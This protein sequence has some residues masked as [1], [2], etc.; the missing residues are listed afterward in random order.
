MERET[1]RQTETEIERDLH[2][3]LLWVV[4]NKEN[5]GCISVDPFDNSE[6]NHEK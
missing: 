6:K 2:V 1:D 3:W 5:V 4:E